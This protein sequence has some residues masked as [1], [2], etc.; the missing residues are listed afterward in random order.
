MTKENNWLYIPE[1][2]KDVE[3]SVHDKDK[4]FDDLKVIY[5]EFE[6]KLLTKEEVLTIQKLPEVSKIL[7]MD[8]SSSNDDFY[9]KQYNEECRERGL[10]AVFYADSGGSGLDCGRYSVYRVS[11][12]GVRFC[13]NHIE[14][15]PQINRKVEIIETPSYNDKSS[16]STEFIIQEIRVNGRT[17]R[18]VEE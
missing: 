8:C 4:S 17:Y 16:N 15:T 1:I 7:K 3:V 18:L 14:G 12:C 13:R 10:V 6:D 9:I 11:Y 2:N 5:G